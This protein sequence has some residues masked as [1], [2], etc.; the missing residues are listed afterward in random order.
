MTLYQFKTLLEE[1]ARDSEESD[2][3]EAQEPKQE[4]F[5]VKSAKD[6]LEVIEYYKRKGANLSG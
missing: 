5:H 2:A 3:P 1:L 6:T 4:V